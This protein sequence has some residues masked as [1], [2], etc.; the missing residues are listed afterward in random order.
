[1]AQFPLIASIFFD[2]LKKHN[3]D[4]S[5][6]F[7][8]HV[9]GNMHRYWYAHD[10]SS[11]KN[12]NKYSTNWIKRNKEAINIG[13]DLLDK[14]LGHLVRSNEF[15]NH[16]LLITSSMG[17]EPNPEFDQKSLSKYDGKIY[18]MDLFINNLSL[19]QKESQNV[20]VKYNY[21]RN[22]A[23]QYGF[24]FSDQKYLNLDAVKD[25]IAGFISFLGFKYKIDKEGFSI[26]VTIDPYTDLNLQKNFSRQACMQRMQR[27]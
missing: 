2:L 21:C 7:S 14:F 12:K 15:R 26:V 23:P 17:Q 8:N 4:Y 27:T 6:L 13:I 20:Q 3:P 11:F 10:I 18:D 1:M 5:S 22:M 19:Y 24:D 25:S 16:T 9:A